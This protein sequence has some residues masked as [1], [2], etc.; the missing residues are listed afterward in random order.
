MYCGKL[1]DS[2]YLG[3]QILDILV[4]SDELGL[5]E[6]FGYLQEI[7]LKSYNEWLRD[8]FFHVRKITLEHQEFKM[9]QEY[10][11]NIIVGNPDIMFYS[12]DFV[13]MDKDL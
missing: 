7:L 6:I 1:Y 3:K 5:N 9:L 12:Q 11:Q 13:E 4:A 10:L 8:N 2:S